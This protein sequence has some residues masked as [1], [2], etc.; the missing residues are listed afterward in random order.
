M[1]RKIFTLSSLVLLSL[2][3]VTTLA[4]V[5]VTNV[6]TS[7]TTEQI[8]ENNTNNEMKEE[9]SKETAPEETVESTSESESIDSGQS[10]ST[11]ETSSTESSQTEETTDSSV[12]T[13][14]SSD[15]E[16]STT[17]STTETTSSSSTT[18][19]STATTESSKPK[20]PK[21]DK[22]KKPEK[23]QPAGKKPAGGVQGPVLPPYGS[24]QTYPTLTGSEFVEEIGRY[25]AVIA[26]KYDLYASV[27]IAQACLETGFGGSSLSQ[28]P[29]HNLFGIKGAY[30]GK[31]VNLGTWEEENGK[32]Y[33]TTAGFRVYPSYQES[34][35]DYVKLL[36]TGLTG[37]G[38]FYKN[39]WKT[40]TLN[41]KQAT[42]ALTGT[43]ATDS[44]YAEKLNGIIEAY[45]LQRFDSEY[46]Y[47][48][49]E[50]ANGVTSNDVVKYSKKTLKEL[51]EWN[52]TLADIEEDQKKA[53]KEAEEA[54][55]RGETNQLMPTTIQ[56]E[57]EAKK[58]EENKKPKELKLVP[59]EKIVIGRKLIK[60]HEAINLNL[61][62]KGKFSVPLAKNKYVVSSEYG[63]RWG[64]NH[65]G[66]DLA[67][68]SGTPIYASSNGV[69]IDSGYSGSAGNY[70]IIQ[71]SDG[72]YTSYFHM[73]R[74][75]ARNNQKLKRGELIGY[76]GSTGDSTGPHLHFAVGSG[77]W[78]GY[79]N[80]RN[81]LDF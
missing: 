69:V 33:T 20:N 27:M 5:P 39:T 34:L 56:Q 73:S 7:A 49:Y 46:S 78:T 3:P 48:F 58:E 26:D 70:V 1:K 21:P 53:A 50:V 15:S 75:A 8:N 63:P 13:T 30:Q 31:S 68:P 67:A 35:L 12:E 57:E 29:Y 59:G 45:D 14:D 43:Y 17:E 64:T 4:A 40:T 36:K 65:N 23:P 32:A 54:A 42:K 51:N 22:T 2:Q 77:L 11:S 6:E 47:T 76:V 81:L 16:T 28:A 52:P 55:K 18:E 74:R 9:A 38:S 37:N 41:Y 66:I 24:I 71:H 19:T 60:A 62:T 25:A 80:P 44:L 79:I 61:V 72:I 10:E